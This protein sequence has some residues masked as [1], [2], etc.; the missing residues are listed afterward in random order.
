M[1]SALPHLDIAQNGEVLS[2]AQ[3]IETMNF[4][5]EG[6]AEHDDLRAFLTTLAARGESIEE[7]TGAARVL[8]EKALSLKA[9]Y[10]A[11][12]CCGTGGDKKGTYNI[13]TAVALV[14]AACGV[15]MAKHGNRASS[16][17]SGAA[18]VLEVLGVNLDLSIKQ[19]EQA[20]QEIG[21]A[22]LMAPQHHSAMQYVRDA[23]KAM[24]THTLFNIL[25]PLANPAGAR[26]QLM[27]VYKRE[28][29]RP[30][31]DVLK[32]L[33]AKRAWV[34][35]GSDGLDE[36]T[37]CGV[38]YVAMLNE[39]GH[40]EEKELVPENFGLSAPDKPERLLG[41]DADENATALRAVLEGQKC[42]YRDIILAN[43]A[44]V[45]CIHGKYSDLKEAVER[46]AKAI[47]NGDANQVL[48]DYIQFS[49]QPLCDKARAES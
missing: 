29:V 24:N 44:A 18:D 20:M 46:A 9:P 6:H 2:E 14:S 27:G 26:Y 8:R 11:V 22:F 36:I 37:T 30:V 13:S 43:T 1:T 31:A 38:T 10:G 15:P 33:G 42:P 7:I 25:G 47:D 32:N 21:F 12:D 3:M 17:K 23:R 41:G 34:V 48:K 45:L 5:M 35:H 49:R 16:S 28:L 4:I 19:L 40:I 39:D